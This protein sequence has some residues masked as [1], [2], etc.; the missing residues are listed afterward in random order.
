MGK[1]FC[2]VNDIE[3]NTTIKSVRKIEKITDWIPVRN[4]SRF[5]CFIVTTG[6]PTIVFF[7]HEI[8]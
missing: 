8:E 7:G 5:E 3:N 6:A 1:H 4:S 2:T